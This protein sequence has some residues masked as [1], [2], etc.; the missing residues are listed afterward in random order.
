[1]D[2]SL[3]FETQEIKE[4]KRPY[5]TIFNLPNFSYDM[6][7]RIGRSVL[8]RLI[9]GVPNAREI[10]DFFQQVPTNDPLNAAGEALFFV[11]GGFV[12]GEVF[13][14]PVSQLEQKCFA[15]QFGLLNE[16]WSTLKLLMASAIDSGVVDQLRAEEL[17][18]RSAQGE[19]FAPHEGNSTTTKST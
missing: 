14:R 2:L 13:Y 18:R 10:Q 5:I 9:K 6:Y 4:C 7:T 12:Q 15:A 19:L 1:L 11:E 8:K 17:D 3:P 16:Q